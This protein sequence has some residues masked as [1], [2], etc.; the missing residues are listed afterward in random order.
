MRKLILATAA[1]VALVVASVAVAHGIEGAKTAKSVAGTFS[2]AAGT[3]S[4]KTCTT[5]DGKTIVV[6]Q[7]KY[8]GTASGDADLTGAVTIQARSVV[9]TTDKVGTVSGQLKVGN[10]TRLAFSTVYDGGSVAGLATG[11]TASKNALLGNLSATFAPETGF[12]GGKIGGTAGGSAVETGGTS[13]KANAG[14]GTERSS[15][16]G[17]ISALS[18]TSI[19]V[20][21]VTCAIPSNLASDAA[22]VKQGDTV[23]IQCAFSNGATTLVKI[24]AAKGHH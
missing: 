17:T 20:A 10:A 4:S 14:P 1:V 11:R 3:V 15:A 16:R 22:K 7:G 2:A 23:E 24:Q 18:S 6:T 21:G 8:T 5:T 9:N 13:C 19:T 12:T